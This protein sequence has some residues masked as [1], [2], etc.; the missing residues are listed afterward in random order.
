MV[1]VAAFWL[2]GKMRLSAERGGFRLAIMS[3]LAVPTKK[4]EDL[5]ISA[6]FKA[7]GRVGSSR[8]VAKAAGAW[9]APFRRY[10]RHL[11][12][13]AMVIGF[14]VDS[15]AFGRIDHPGPHLIFVGYLAVAV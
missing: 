13:A 14:G 4:K 3:R 10:E 9:T 5:K 15:V 11:S 1:G 7:S 6:R 2:I 8:G 12:A